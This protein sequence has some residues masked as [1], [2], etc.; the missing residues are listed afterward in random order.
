M[1]KVKS[2]SEIK[3]YAEDVRKF[4]KA[5]LAKS[6]GSKDEQYYLGKMHSAKLIR[7]W[8]GYTGIIKWGRSVSNR[9]VTRDV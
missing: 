2:A 4:S 8:I 5:M 3:Q 1:R 7:D 6:K 9:K